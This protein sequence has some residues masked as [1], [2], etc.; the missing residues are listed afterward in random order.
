M[1][2]DAKRLLKL[3]QVGRRE[4]GLDEEE[5]RALLEQV[6]GARSAKGMSASKLDAVITAMKGLGFKVKGGAQVAGR[7][8]PPSS[9]KVQAPEVRKLRAIWITMKQ[10]GLLHD[11]S[12]DAL[13]S[14]IRRMTASA[15]GGVGIGRAEWLTSAQAERVLEALKKWHIR[16][17][18]AAIIERGDIVPASRGHQIDAMPGYD[19][20]REAYENP[21]W[22][23]AQIMVIDGSKPVSEIHDKAP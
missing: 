2:P 9:A 18:T 11:G 8:S 12:E 1:Q 14:F 13:G 15:N 4:L 17:M 3:V 7:R 22:R 20:I 19:L 5:Y 23:P 21:G 6:T 10:D 16:L